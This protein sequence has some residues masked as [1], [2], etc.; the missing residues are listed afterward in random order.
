M[1][2]D[3]VSI[4]DRIIKGSIGTVNYI[5]HKS[6]NPLLSTIYVKL[7]DSKAGNSLKDRR[8]QNELKECVP[9]TALTKRFPFKK[10]KTTV[11]VERK[12]FPAI[13]GHAI[14]VHKSQGS[15]LD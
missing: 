8:L 9:I 13:L 4:S 3:N 7:D 11:M 14:T 1:L 15:T 12:Q 6:Q 5:D 10:G 2:T